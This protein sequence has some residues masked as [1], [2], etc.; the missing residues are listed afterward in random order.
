LVV[1]LLLICLICEATQ[2]PWPPENTYVKR[3]TQTDI[4]IYGNLS[5]IVVTF[6][7]PEKHSGKI[8]TLA[9]LTV[10]DVLH[11]SNSSPLHIGDTIPVF[12]DGG[13]IGNQT[14]WRGN[15][16]MLRD[17]EGPYPAQIY[18][19]VLDKENS[20]HMNRYY[21][22]SA[23]LFKPY[24]EVKRDIINLLSGKITTTQILEREKKKRELWMQNL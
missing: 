20:F 23:D 11:Q 15:K 13:S 6:E 4:L 18:S 22:L 16:G 19:L 9:N 21:F 7:D 12:C 8:I 10:L 1:S 2:M 14:S 3:I 24:D 5:H 17:G